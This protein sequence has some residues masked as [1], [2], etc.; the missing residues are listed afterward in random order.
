MLKLL[1]FTSHGLSISYKLQRKTFH[2]LSDLY[3]QRIIKFYYSLTYIKKS[4]IY[5][6]ISPIH[7]N[8][9]GKNNKN[10]ELF[11][12]KW[13]IK[14]FHKKVSGKKSRNLINAERT[15]FEPANRFCRLHAFQ[16]CLFNH[17]STSPNC[18]RLQR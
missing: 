11:D 9:R 6:F 15:G 18:L 7:R 1:L 8:K 2:V 12:R 4:I 3:H 16:A 14:R 5:R 17:S 10:A 13:L